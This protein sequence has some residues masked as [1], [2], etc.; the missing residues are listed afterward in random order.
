MAAV[1]VSA[2]DQLDAGGICVCGVGGD[3]GAG[4]VCV[5]HGTRL[6]G[7]GDCVLWSERIKSMEGSCDGKR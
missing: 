3:A 5:Y 2:G 4:G 7:A 6:S 1:A